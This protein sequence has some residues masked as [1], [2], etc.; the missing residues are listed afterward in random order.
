MSSH[1]A[2][3]PSPLPNR[4]TPEGCI[5]ALAARGTLMGNRGGRLHEGF[6]LTRRRWVS[7]RWII[8]RLAFRGRRRQVMG[9]GYTELF[10][11]DEAT[12]LAAGHRPCF[13]CRRAEAQRFAALWAAATG[14]DLPP[15]ADAID[16]VLH[17]ERLGPRIRLAAGALPPGALY[18]H[19]ARCWLVSGT[20]RAR[21]WTPE[22]YGPQTPLPDAEVTA[23]TPPGTRAVL[24]RGYAPL[25]HPSATPD[26]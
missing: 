16:A 1:P 20:G 11:L 12:A 4:V 25:L 15:R 18:L 17:R 5:T 23:L 19:A 14:A 2:A 26:A 9:P 7:R 6:A 21:P 3:R 10:F 8:C 22:G 24:A 13:E